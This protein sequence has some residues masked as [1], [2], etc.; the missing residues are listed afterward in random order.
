MRFSFREISKERVEEF[1]QKGY[2]KRD[3]LPHRIYYLPKCGPDSFKLVHRMCGKSA[4]NKHWEVVLYAT[5]PLIDEIPEELFFDNDLIWHQQQFGKTGHIAFAC[6]VIK[7]GNLYGLNYI[8]DPV[9]RISRRREYKTRIENRFK[10]WPHM[11]LNSIMNFAIENNIKKIYSPTSELAIENTDPKRNVKRELFERVYDRAVNKYFLVKKEGKWWIIDVAKNT[12]NVIIPAKK[13]EMTEK[14]KTICLCHDIERGLGHIDV[15]PNFAELAN[16]TSPNNLE[17]MLIIEK[18]MNVKATYN[19]LGCFFNEVRERIEK[20]GHCIGFHSYDH[21]IYTLW[22]YSKIYYKIVD[23]VL[24]FWPYSKIFYKVVDLILR[25]T[26]NRTHTKYIGQLAKCRQVDYRVKGYRAPQ[27]KITPELSDENLC[28]HNFEWLASSARSLGMRLPKMENRIVKI[29]ILFDDFKM[30][31][32]KM[33][34]E[35]WE[36]KAIDRIKQNDFVAFC[37]HDCYAHYWLPYY[38]EFLDKIKG[39]GELKTLNEVANEVILGSSI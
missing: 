36:Q 35:D 23:I 33:K 3:F 7:E 30:Y 14:G 20:D 24:K 12:D 27:S 26:I 19:V 11:L 10:G 2:K 15:D 29:P 4:A 31:N 38:K 6:L 16:K 18:E 34:Y 5:S 21:K 22:L 17:A 28:Y 25:N 39:L 37:L 8:S 32:N 13:Q 1:F 9:Q